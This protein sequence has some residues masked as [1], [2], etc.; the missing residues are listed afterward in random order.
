MEDKNVNDEGLL[1][2]TLLF[3][4]S[5][6]DL[7]NVKEQLYSAAEH[8]EDSYYKNDQKQ[9]L[10]ESLK[11]YISK[12]LTKTID[13]LGSVT[14]KLNNFLD[15]NLN[16]VSTTNLRVLCM[17]QRLRTCHV[18]ANNVGQ[19]Q[20]TVM[21]QT[22]KYPKK[23]ILPEGKG[24]CEQASSKFPPSSVDFSFTKAVSNTRLEK[25][26]RSMSPL[27]MIKRSESASCV[28]RSMSPNIRRR[29]CSLYPQRERAK[30]TEVYPKK[31]MNLF[32]V[33]LRMYKSKN[34]A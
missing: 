25:R 11:D 28:R 7:R 30:D 12:S 4:D 19:S 13:H 26:S 34:K 33:L 6:K 27:R 32:K 9:I 10:L 18:Y 8:F 29:S 17:E 3:A 15:H 21:T 5:L 1:R 22:L 31:T 14:Y 23:Y 2:H 20:Q 16:Q 24:Y